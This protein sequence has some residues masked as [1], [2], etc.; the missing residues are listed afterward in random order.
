MKLSQR[1]DVGR[2]IG[3]CRSQKGANHSYSLDKISEATGIPEQF[4]RKIFQTL[5]KSG[6]INSFKGKGGA[7]LARSPGNITVSQ[8]IEPLERGK[9]FTRCLRN[10]YC[11]RSVDCVASRFWQKTE[12]KLFEILSSTTL[13]DLIEEGGRNATKN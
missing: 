7:S 4:L 3:L 6:I 10:E 9:S 12:K 11:S 13:K 2:M 8:V 1:A 5:V